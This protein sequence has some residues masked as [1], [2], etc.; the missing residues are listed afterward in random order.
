MFGG[1]DLFLPIARTCNF[2][3]LGV[4]IASFLPIFAY[5]DSAELAILN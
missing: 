2:Q 5:F 3:N 4:R 1:G